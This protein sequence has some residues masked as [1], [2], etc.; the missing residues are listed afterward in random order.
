MRIAIPKEIHTG[1]RRV[2]ATPQTVIR[3]K[4]MG[5]DVAVQSG[6]GEAAGFSDAEYAE[7]GAV[8]AAAVREVWEG[9]DLVLKVRPPE[10]HAELGVHEADLLRVGAVLVGFI[11]P[12]QHKSLLDRLAARR[13]TTLAM[14]CVPRISRAQT[15]D[16]LS[17]MANIAGYRAIVEAAAH[18]GRFF[19]GQ[20]TAAGKVEPAKVLVIGAGVAGLS[21]V[22]T[23]R[24]LGAVVRAFDPRP[25]TRDQVRSLGAEFLEVHVKEEGEGT[26]GYAKTM[27]DAFLQA[28]MALFSAQ[29]MEVDIIV[30]TALVPGKA[31]P[32]LITAG[33]VES[34][35]PGSVIVD[36]AAEQGGNCALTQPGGI[37]VHKGV[38][39]I[40]YT[41]L[42]SRMPSL[43]SQ[44]FGS[45]AAAL[46]E[47]VLKD[48]TVRIDLKDEV[49]R[50]ALATHEGQVTWPAPA[51][52]VPPPPPEPGVAAEVRAASGAA[53]RGHAGAAASGSGGMLWLAAAGAGLI[54]LGAVAPASFM[55]HF[56]VFVLAC[57]V[58]WQVVWN[59][60]PALHTPLMSVTNAV[61]GI[62]LIGG[63][64]QLGGAPASATV[65]LGALAVFIAT[66]NI[67]GGFL[68]TG[69]ML[70][71]FRR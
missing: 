57:F 23:A 49:V 56:T 50:G 18:F 15:M 55:S 29:A 43:A 30:T 37:V 68:V 67:A 47:A 62:I 42:P 34:M 39:I 12:S 22:G 10:E 25:A 36:L 41:D 64:L 60:K 70:A 40:G 6:A 66:V 4:R 7:A 51:P 8:V 53:S 65:I 11:W 16:A 44:M 33:M 1:E 38:T 26:G 19:G 52:S 48:G 71:M 27:S 3:L 21:A 54:G 24:G 32:R 5:L 13:V 69:R 17:A 20:I 35:R 14:D 9:A 58:G 46:V 2:A 63:M 61:S 28:E 31:A 45:T 59:V